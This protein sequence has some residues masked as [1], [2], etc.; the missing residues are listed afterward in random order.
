M[1]TPKNTRSL[2]IIAREIEAGYGQSTGYYAAKPYVDAMKQLTFITDRFYDDDADTIVIYCL[3][4]LNGWRGED[5]RR[6]KAELKAML[7]R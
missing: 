2:S 6:V 3:S 5:A 7:K 4:N 1:N